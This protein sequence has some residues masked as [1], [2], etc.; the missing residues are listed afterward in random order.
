MVD[1]EASLRGGGAPPGDVDRRDPRACAQ[2]NTV[3]G[4]CAWTQSGRSTRRDYGP[5]SRLGRFP[6][7]IGTGSAEAWARY[8]KQTIQKGDCSA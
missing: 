2:G 4:Q 3:L 5:R 6:W 7:E 1:E 8:A